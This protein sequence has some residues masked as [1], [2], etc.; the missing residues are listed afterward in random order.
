LTGNKERLPDK[1]YRTGKKNRKGTKLE[2]EN[3]K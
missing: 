3:E 2:R 1:D